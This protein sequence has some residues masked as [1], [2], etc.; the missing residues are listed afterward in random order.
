[1][2]R[3][4]RALLVPPAPSPSA[5]PAGPSSLLG[6]IER[7]AEAFAADHHTAPRSWDQVKDFVE[8]YW[9]PVMFADLS[10]TSDFPE[11]TAMAVREAAERLH[12]DRGTA[13]KQL[14]RYFDRFG[15]SR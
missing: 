14:R 7:A 4:P 2:R 6:L 9:K 12:S 13:V 11:L 8:N 1:M 10:A 5:T 3:S 15:A